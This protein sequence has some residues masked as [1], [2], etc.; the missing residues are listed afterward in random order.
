MNNLGILQWN[1]GKTTYG[2][3]SITLESLDFNTFKI[4]VLQEHSSDLSKEIRANK[5]LNYRDLI[6]KKEFTRVGFY[7]SKDITIYSLFKYS[8]DVQRLRIS[9]NNR[10]INIINIYN[11]IN[12]SITIPKIAIWQDIKK[13]LIDSKQEEIIV[14][15]DFNLKHSL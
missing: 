3:S 1:C 9:F 11:P 12:P 8:K 15:G 7:I 6:D 14:L 2:S 13:A 5:I 10:I 4:L